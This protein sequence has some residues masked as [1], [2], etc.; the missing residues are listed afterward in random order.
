VADTH[1]V[2]VDDVYSKLPSPPACGA[3]PKDIEALGPIYVQAGAEVVRDQ[4]A[5]AAVRLATVLN[6]ALN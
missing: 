2:A 6:T 5:K 1:K 3:P 4:L